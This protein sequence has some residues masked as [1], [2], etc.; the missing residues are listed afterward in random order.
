VRWVQ[1]SREESEDEGEKGRWCVERERERESREGVVSEGMGRVE[2]GGGEE[3]ARVRR[4]R[5]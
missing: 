1:E 3:G 2:G 5:G 4:V